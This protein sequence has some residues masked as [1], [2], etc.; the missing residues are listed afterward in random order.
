[1][2]E[3]ERNTENVGSDFPVLAEAMHKGEEAE[4]P[5]RGTGTKKEI[6]HLEDAGVPFS[7]V[8]VSKLDS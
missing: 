4:R 5:I 2:E 7:I 8:R 3:L 6:E 1:V